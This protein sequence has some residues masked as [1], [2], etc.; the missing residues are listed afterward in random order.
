[1]SKNAIYRYFVEGESE[2]ILINALKTDLGLI[3]PGK[4]DILNVIQ[5]KINKNWLRTMKPNTTVILVY[6]TDVE[7]VELL[8]KNIETLK[9]CAAVKD[10]WCIPQVKNFE[11]ELVSACNIRN[12]MDLTGTRTLHDHKRAFVNNSNQS[13]M[14][15]RNG[16]DIEK[17][18]SK[19]PDNAFA[20]FGN[21]SEKI[22]K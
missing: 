10:V 19:V 16:F 7:D 3:V 14:L 18:W 6:D 5:K 15:E 2:Q 1:M 9:K 13:Q 8:K 22:K 21:D 11:D 4:V 12:V 17:L 20:Q